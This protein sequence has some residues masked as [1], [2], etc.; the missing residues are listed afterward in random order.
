MEIISKNTHPPDH[1]RK[2]HIQNSRFDPATIGEGGPINFWQHC[3]FV[4]SQYRDNYDD[5]KWKEE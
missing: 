5:V 2:A 3:G 4:T 1:I